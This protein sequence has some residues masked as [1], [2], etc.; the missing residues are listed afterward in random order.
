MFNINFLKAC[1]A[2][3]TE[4]KFCTCSVYSSVRYSELIDAELN[5]I[6]KPVTFVGIK[7]SSNDCDRQTISKFNWRRAEHV[8]VK[9][10]WQQRWL[11]DQKLTTSELNSNQPQL[12]N[13]LPCRLF[14]SKWKF[15][16]R[17]SYCC[18]VLSDGAAA[19]TL[20]NDNVYPLV[21]LATQQYRPTEYTTLI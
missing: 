2:T 11:L 16:R 15:C 7:H 14:L 8:H 5:K 12:R 17:I 21:L 9:L 13:R 10:I 4:N 19:V 18:S 1:D 20:T 6:W 3:W